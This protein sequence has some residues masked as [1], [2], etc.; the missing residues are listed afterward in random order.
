VG[1]AGL[2]L[3]LRSRLNS[4]G[5]TLGALLLV[6]VPLLMMLKSLLALEQ[7][8]A[9]GWGRVRTVVA[10]VEPRRV[11]VRDGLGKGAWRS[12]RI[13]AAAQDGC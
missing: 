1:G 9:L 8:M 2:V 10:L 7:R 6:L 11:V 13:A 3:S 12:G 4:V 5:V